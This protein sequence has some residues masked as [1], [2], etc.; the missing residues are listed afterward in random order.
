MQLPW[1]IALEL[2]HSRSGFGSRRFVNFFILHENDHELPNMSSQ[3]EGYEVSFKETL[4]KKLSRSATAD[5]YSYVKVLLLYWEVKTEQDADF[6]KEGRLL[7]NLLAKTFNYSVQE[8]P[9]PLV[10]PQ[11]SLQ[12]RITEEIILASEAA[13]SSNAKALVVIHY[14]GHGDDRDKQG[15]SVWAR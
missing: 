13:R 12:R 2:T 4:N 3:D 7:G 1:L 6:R 10:H 14:G 5:H 11:L 15:R 9:I 8:F